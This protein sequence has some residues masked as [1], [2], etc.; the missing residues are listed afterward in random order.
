MKI[1]LIDIKEDAQQYSGEMPADMLGFADEEDMRA[2]GPVLYDMKVCIVSD[3]LIARGTLA[4][5]VAFRCCRCGEFYDFVV[6]ETD[7]SFALDLLPGDLPADEQKGHTAEMTEFIEKRAHEATFR[8]VEKG[9]EFVDLTPDMR[10]SIILRFPGYPIC[11][12]ACQ[13]RCPKCGHNLNT[14]QCSCEP[15]PVDDRW[16]SLDQLEMK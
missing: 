13:G 10:E 12:E 4:A 8:T 6:K 7:Y 5:P 3:M 1:R 9:I 16:G 2:A 15:E 11:D 14:E